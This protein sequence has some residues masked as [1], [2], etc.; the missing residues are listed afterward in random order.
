MLH[1]S[2]QINT[3]RQRVEDEN[4]ERR[5]IIW[6]SPDNCLADFP[7]LDETELR[8]ITCGV[9]QL[10]LSSSYMQEYLEGNSEIFV[11][12]EDDHLI[13]VR[14]QSR[15]TSSRTY[16][17]WIEY[18]PTEVTAWYCICR[19]GA[20]VV[21]VCSHIASILWYLGYARHK[22]HISYGVRKL[23]ETLRRW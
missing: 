3:L 17:L 4:L 18:S 20:R 21:G 12:Q 8:N 10:K 11:H 6:K 14:L 22:P 13:Y 2:R 1:L 16:L 23:G 5:F 15:H 9:Y 19:A 7:H